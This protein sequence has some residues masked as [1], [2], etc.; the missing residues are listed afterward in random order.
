MDSKEI[1]EM[2][3]EAKK[4]VKTALKAMLDTSTDEAVKEYENK[5]RIVKELEKQLAEA[6]TIDGMKGKPKLPETQRERPS[7]LTEEE[8]TFVSN[9]REAVSKGNTFTGFLPRTV[10][11]Q[12]QAKKEKIAKLRGLCSVH[13]VTGDYTLYVA[14]DTVSVSY[15]GEGTQFTESNPSIKPV[16]LSAL[17]LGCLIKVTNEFIDDLGA[18]VLAFITDECAKAFARKEDAEILFGTGTG[19]SK[20]AIRG[21]VTNADPAK[22]I[23][24][25]SASTITWK[26]VKETIQAIGAY[27]GTATIVC[28]QAFLDICH[29][30]KD[31]STY[32]FPQNME[33]KSLMGVPVV[34]SDA[35]PTLAKQ[36]A[37]M[38]VGD[39][40]YYHLADR[41]S[42]EIVTLKERFAEMGQVGILAKERIDGDIALKD[43]FAVLK[44]ADA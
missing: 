22:I 9:L 31:G 13:K 10:S 7:S 19:S 35:F 27:R 17:K 2:L 23:K 11:A 43:A 3:E 5:V 16:G 21:I 40:S 41:D 15:V 42:M 39:F 20:T 24:A 33:I 12:I 18:D 14:G 34:V 44:M 29:E 36:T 4:S 25:T 6:E 28:S 32:M 1:K 8:R 38:V 26:E 37:V 30:F